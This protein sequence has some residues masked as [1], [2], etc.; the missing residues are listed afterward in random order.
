[1]IST[2]DAV[3]IANG[4]SRI[5]KSFEREYVCGFVINDVEKPW[6]TQRIVLIQKTKPAWQAGLWNGVGGKVEAGESPQQAM[7]REFAEETGV[8]VTGWRL[9]A[10]NRH[11]PNGVYMFVSRQWVDAVHQTTDERP[12]IWEISVL[13]SGLVVPNLKW[14]VPLALSE[15][16]E[17]VLV[18]DDTLPEGL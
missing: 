14:L 2:Q 5:N 4:T 10:I 6:K 1:M 15:N 11:G 3:S 18:G 17:T 13:K 8:R 12:Q 9:F 16:K 7:I